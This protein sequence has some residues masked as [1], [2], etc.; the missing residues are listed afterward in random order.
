MGSEGTRDGRVRGTTTNGRSSR[1]VAGEGAE[2]GLEG[3]L[4][5]WLATLGVASRRV[6]FSPSEMNEFT[7]RIWPFE[8]SKASNFSLCCDV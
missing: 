4:A 6:G 3:R 5:G 7:E 2:R 8:D 1:S